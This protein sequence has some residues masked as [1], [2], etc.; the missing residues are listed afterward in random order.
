[1]YSESHTDIKDINKLFSVFRTNFIWFAYNS[2]HTIF[3]Q[4][5]PGIVSFMKVRAVK[6]ILYFM[7]YMRFVHILYI[8]H[9]LWNKFSTGYVHRSLLWNHEFGEN[10]CSKIH[11][12]FSI[13]E[14]CETL[15][16]ESHT[17][18]IVISKIT[19]TC[20][21]CDIYNVRNALVQSCSLSLST[22]PAVLLTNYQ[23]C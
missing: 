18:L 9:P 17:S 11:A 3:M 16:R 23:S 8:F 19:F 4:H 21:Q 15:C 10:Q 12:L 22:S 7:M 5:C 1:M 2:V 14:F 13:Y 20:V 6:V